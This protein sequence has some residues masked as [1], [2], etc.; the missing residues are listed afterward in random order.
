[1]SYLCL[2]LSIG[3]F[4]ATAYLAFST[5][6]LQ[7]K[8]KSIKLSYILVAGA[9]L[10]V[11]SVMLFADYRAAYGKLAA[12]FLALFHTI[13]VML[14]GY[15][16]G[17]LGEAFRLVGTHTW[18]TFFYLS[19]LLFAA[20]ICTFSFVLSF[21]ES[22]TS[23]FRYFTTRKNDIF[24][25]SELSEKSLALA[26]SIREKFPTAAIA[27]MNVFSESDEAAYDLI[28]D[29]KEIKAIFFKK[30]I[31]E[32]GLKLRGSDTRTVFF[33]LSENESVNLEAS[34][35][36]IDKFNSRP[37]T[38]VYTFS[39]SKEGELLLDSVE[40][41]VMK[42]RRINEDRSLAHSII[43]NSLITEHVTV[44]KDKKIISTLIVGF[45]GYGT[46][47]AKALLWCGQL[48]GYDLEIN[49]IDKENAEARFQSECPEIISLNGN[50]QFGEARYNLKFFNE[51]DIKT[52]RLHEIV[53]TLTNTSV[54]YVSLGNDELN[55]ETA[56]NLR[57]LFE[58]IGL[59]PVIRAIVYSDIKYKILETRNLVNYTGDSYDI[60][61]I[62]N[63]SSRFSYN[64]IINEELE[65]L[66]LNCHLS[67]AKSPDDTPEKWEVKKEKAIKEFEKSE[68]C[69]NSSMA[70]AI[71]DKY[72]KAEHLSGE[73]A[74]ITEHMR[75]CAYMRT[76]GYIFSGSRDKSSRNDRAKMHHN[77]HKS[78][79][80][81]DATIR[82]DERIV[83]TTC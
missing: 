76:E 67:W 6:K 63:I 20:P 71:H 69:R 49:V 22:I 15:D 80:L 44:R 36:I 73:T 52:Y 60:E 39:T 46:E 27:F 7:K 19:F 65:E 4:I 75:W 35:N 16:F 61:I 5:S 37:K 58:R 42:V 48:P 26:K 14:T 45:G 33:T 70:T 66:A 2:I 11:F 55:I 79:L 68:Y 24:V 23:Y 82:I 59:Y 72:R 51:V 12:I 8:Y 74:S 18:I 13:Q 9:F 53:S 25:L 47:I 17:N 77:L 40:H 30:D 32:A 41:G 1:M 54:V 78:Q 62:G 43:Y 10:S 28:E 38:E 50:E 3:F 56:I 31:T 81:D 57:I 83:N 21:F 64:S 34:L 29:A